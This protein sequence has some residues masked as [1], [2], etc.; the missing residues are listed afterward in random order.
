MSW[1]NQVPMVDVVK[2]RRHFHLNPELS[3]QEFETSQYIYDV[4]TEIGGLELER[5]T[6]T[7]V[8]ATLKGAKPGKTVA[9]R[10]DMDAL[11]IFEEADVNFKSTKDGVMHACGHDAHTAMLL[12][13]TK[14]LVGMRDQLEGTVKFIY[15]H[16]EEKLPGGAQEL[17]KAGVMEGVDEIYGIHIS[18]NL[19]VGQ[20]AARPGTMNATPDSFAITIQGRG[21]HGAYPKGSIDPI[22]VGAELVMALQTIVSRNV[23]PGDKAVV[24][25]GKFSSGEADNVIPDTAEILGTVRTITP[26]VRALIKERLHAIVEHVTAMNGATYDLTYTHGYDLVINDQEKY[27]NVLRAGEKVV[28]AE[29]VLLQEHGMGGEDFSAYMQDTPGCFFNLGTGTEAEGC[30]YSCHHPKLKI[31]ED[32]ME[33]GVKMEVQLV[34]DALNG[35]IE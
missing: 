34:L 9:L 31:I 19:P 3:F 28:G 20:I 33:V 12:G 8:V 6:P 15:Q 21:S 27:E 4:L 5:L 14:M 22:V 17:V 7:S 10:A 23:D 1:K 35:N 18:P 2:W 24:T 26:E 13:A 30:G 29:N 16:A 25:V 11:P 32:A